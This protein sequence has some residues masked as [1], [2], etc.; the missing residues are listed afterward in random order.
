M[1]TDKVGFEWQPFDATYI[2]EWISVTTRFAVTFS[3]LPRCA[4]NTE[5]RFPCNIEY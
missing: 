5:H 4:T 2:F 3:E 1:I